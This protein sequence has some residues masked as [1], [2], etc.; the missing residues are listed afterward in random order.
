M[1]VSLSQLQLLVFFVGGGGCSGGASKKKVM[2]EAETRRCSVRCV[3]VK[4]LWIKE[5]VCV[6]VCWVFIKMCAQ[7]SVDAKDAFD[8]SSIS[9]YIIE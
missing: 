3:K 1:D 2:S 7:Q 4:S 9:R 8:S 5:C 6:C